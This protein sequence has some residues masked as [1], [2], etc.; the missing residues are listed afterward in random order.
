LVPRNRGES[1]NHEV[2]SLWHLR[3]GRVAVA[4]HGGSP[5]NGSG[6]FE[7]GGLDCSFAETLDRSFMHEEKILILHFFRRLQLFLIRFRS[8]VF[9][10]HGLLFYSTRTET[11]RLLSDLILPFCRASLPHSQDGRGFIWVGWLF[12]F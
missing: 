11:M 4:A 1:Q 10:W 6:V 9:L 5:K 12:G 7:T 3:S 2:A 8:V